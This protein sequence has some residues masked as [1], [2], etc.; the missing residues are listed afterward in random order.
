M[1]K[2]KVFDLSLVSSVVDLKIGM[3]WIGG[4]PGGYRKDVKGTKT[5][6]VPNSFP[7][8]HGY[9]PSVLVFQ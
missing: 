5:F 3:C 4:Q 1:I 7:G 2:R 6:L 9:V 8:G